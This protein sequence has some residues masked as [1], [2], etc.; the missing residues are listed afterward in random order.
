LPC[1]SGQSPQAR[2][3]TYAMIE[4]PVALA[5]ASLIGE[6]IANQKTQRE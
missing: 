1:A 3:I 5:G 2:F 6:V 4:S